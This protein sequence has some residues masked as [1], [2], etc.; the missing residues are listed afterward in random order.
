MAL[1]DAEGWT[2]DINSRTISSVHLE[3]S[4]SVPRLE[5]PLERDGTALVD[6]AADMRKLR[7]E[8]GKPP[9]REMARRAYFPSTTLSDAASGRR[10]PSLAVTMAFVR[11]C[12]GNQADWET[13][14]HALAVDLSV[15]AEE[16]E[17]P[18]E[19]SP[20]VGLAAYGLTTPSCSRPAVAV[21]R[22]GRRSPRTRP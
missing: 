21:S 20:H 8:A 2:P 18:A 11:A 10:L 22:A 13:R 7:E 1:S 19:G 17:L 15:N 9:Y 4:G 12:G 16:A 6:F 5:N 3:G 14:W